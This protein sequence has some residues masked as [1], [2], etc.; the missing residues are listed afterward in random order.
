MKIIKFKLKTLLLA[1]LCLLFI[2]T[3][4][5]SAKDSGNLSKFK[6]ATILKMVKYIDLDDSTEKKFCVSGDK[7]IYELLDNFVKSSEDFSKTSIINIKSSTK[8]PLCDFI[9][10][11]KN[12][13]KKASKS[14]GHISNFSKSIVTISDS[15][16]FIK[17]RGGIIELYEKNGRLRYSLNLKKAKSQ[18]IRINSKLIETADRIY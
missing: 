5:I 16:N 14:M 4:S 17:N 2:S 9:Y 7:K 12:N 1:A 11:S 10:L 8:L 18:D 15:E 13:K 3:E 6:A